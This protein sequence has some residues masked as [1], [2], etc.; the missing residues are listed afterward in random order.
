MRLQW[1]RL[2]L[3][4]TAISLAAGCGGGDVSWCFSGGGA[5]GHCEV[6]PPPGDDGGQRN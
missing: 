2:A 4:A 5:A 6:Q 3:L 1:M